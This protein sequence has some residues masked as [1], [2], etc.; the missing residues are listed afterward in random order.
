VTARARWPHGLVDIAPAFSPLVYPARPLAG[1]L[2]PETVP[3]PPPAEISRGRTTLAIV[4]AASA[5]IAVVAIAAVI[6]AARHG[7]L[8]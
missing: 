5:S 6:F 4:G 3:P 7:L 1:T 2:M 8:G